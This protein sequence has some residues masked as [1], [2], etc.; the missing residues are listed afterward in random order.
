MADYPEE[1]QNRSNSSYSSGGSYGASS[2]A[3]GDGLGSLNAPRSEVERLQRRTRQLEEQAHA[4]LTVLEGVANALS[5]EVDLSPL[6]RR[7]ALVA[8]RLTGADIGAVYL[9]D[10]NGA[11]LVE[12]IESAQTAAESN[13]LS[14]LAAHEAP[15]GPPSGGLALSGERP[16]IALG[17]GVAGRV[18][19]SGEFTLIGDA[20]TDQRFAP[21]VLALDSAL[22]GVQLGSLLVIP[23]VFRN[24]VTGILEVAKRAQTPGFDVRSLE[25]MRTL[26]AQAAVAVA[27]VQ[28]F[29]RLRSERDRIIQTQEEERK[30]LGQLLHDGPAQKLSQIAQRLGIAENLV[31]NDPVNGVSLAMHE[32]RLASESALNTAHEMR[33]LLFD[34]RPLVLDS[35]HGGLIAA[36]RFFLK[37]FN[38]GQGPH[39]HFTA[40]YPQRLS[41]NVELT[42]FAIIQEAVNNVLKH[43]QAKNC[44]IDVRETVSGLVATVRDDG[45]GFDVRQVQQEYENRGSWGMLSMHERAELLQGTLAIAS[46]PG[47]GS[48]VT[49]TAPRP[50][51]APR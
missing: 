11:L 51:D 1:Q 5:A 25:I 32:V 7:I 4:L 28:L 18:A 36:L 24:N 13:I 2:A 9:S 37:R 35:E 43:A 39:I 44:W 15:P 6:L 19:K 47:R 20:A 21:D 34:L 42:A 10:A 30:R 45:L 49:L 38:D 50:D 33:N 22:L 3:G 46:Q 16:R 40:D 29:Q 8:I 17:Q 41:H 48:V 23:M 12:A 31:A 26:A 27:N 14:P